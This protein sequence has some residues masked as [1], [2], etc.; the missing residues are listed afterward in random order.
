NWEIGSFA[1]RAWSDGVVAAARQAAELEARIEPGSRGEEEMLS[2]LTRLDGYRGD[3]AAWHEHV[4][5][6]RAMPERSLEGMDW[7]E[8]ALVEGLLLQGRHDEAAAIVRDAT[9]ART[10]GLSAIVG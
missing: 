7:A 10:R 2:E 5:R 1:L 3:W 6:L 9:G 4:E 8:R